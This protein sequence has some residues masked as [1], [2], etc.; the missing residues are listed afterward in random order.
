MLVNKLERE[1]SK[2]EVQHAEFVTQL[3]DPS[4]YEDRD[5]VEDLNQKLISN[6]KESAT[7]NLEWEKAATELS[8]ME[9]Q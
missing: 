7:R 8:E 5:A 2:L 9:E 4:L 3:Q 1:I 6:R